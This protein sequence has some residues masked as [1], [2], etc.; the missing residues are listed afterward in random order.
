MSHGQCVSP[1]QYVSHVA[2]VCFTVS[3]CL[4]SSV[5]HMVSGPVC[6][7]AV[8]WSVCLIWS[9]C[10][11]WA[12]VSHIGIR[13]AIPV[14]KRLTVTNPLWEDGDPS[15][16][17]RMLQS[18]GGLYWLGCPFSLIVPL[19]RSCGI[20]VGTAVRWRTVLVG[21]SIQSYSAA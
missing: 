12:C 6:S 3:V 15:V 11:T 9:L 8:S 7:W 20:S 1:R 19:D 5:S 10:F 17:L 21:M 2:S 16:A 18:D 14:S 13:Q 4:M